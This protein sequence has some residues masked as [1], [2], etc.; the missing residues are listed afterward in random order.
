MSAAPPAHR[1]R[2]PDGSAAGQTIA[3]LV[4]LLLSLPL[5]PLVLVVVAV[6]RVRDRL[7]TTRAA[8]QPATLTQPATAIQP[9]VL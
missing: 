8:R 2:R 4:I 9:P 1:V 6:V 5:L 7:T 3:M